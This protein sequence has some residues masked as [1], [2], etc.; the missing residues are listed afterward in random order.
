[1]TNLATE[2]PIQYSYPGYM[3]IAHPWAQLYKFAHS[4]PGPRC[5]CV[6]TL[7]LTYAF[8]PSLA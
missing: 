7:G 3:P 6:A 5:D 1:M 4:H 8:M 2:I